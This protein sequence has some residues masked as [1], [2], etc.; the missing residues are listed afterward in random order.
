[1]E[2]KLK[3]ITEAVKRNSKE[4]VNNLIYLF[5]EDNLKQCFYELKKNKAVG[6][7]KITIS[8][9]ERN[10]KDNIKGLVERMKKWQYKPQVI[11]RVYIPKSDGRSRP[12]GI[13][14][15]ED[16]IVQMGIKKILEAIY[17]PIFIDCSYGFRQ[18]RNC[19][20]AINKLD[21]LIM[22]ENV[23]FIIDAD[24]KSFFDEMEHS[25]LMKFLEDK[26]SDKSL[27]RLIIRILKG[28]VLEMGRIIKIKKG[29][30]QGAILSP[31][32][33]NIYLHYVLD[34][35]IEKVI[36]KQSIGQISMVRYADDFVICA[37]EES[38]AKDLVVKL[39][40]RFRKFG[41]C[42]ST[43][44]TKIVK[45][46][47]KS[48]KGQ[49]KSFNFLGFT[50][51]NAKTRKGYYKVGI[52]TDSKRMSKSLKELNLWL[53]GIRNLVKI[54]VWWKIL[55]A[56]LRGYFQY[57]GISGNMLWLKKYHSIVIRKVYKWIN[58]RSQK[59]SFNWSQFSDY[60]KLYPLPKPKIYHNM[61]TMFN[62]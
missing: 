29:T 44:K 34:L 24:I 47:K 30:P 54:N 2:T 35:W 9:Y 21:K 14:T 51:Y 40:E 18:V 41:L 49:G 42:L 5:N 38:E 28:G 37:E 43:G 20:Q 55:T 58:R 16:K 15:V 31:V 46:G 13:S 1:M 48:G 57:Y 26:I 62:C 61:Y 25:W 19:H 22:E 32:L 10:L 7:D 23:N 39:K 27:L 50:F 52:K 8:E 17:E 6:V 11:K 45:F 12:I 3:L 56:K 33:A 60:L 36:K 59:K 4:K 53:K